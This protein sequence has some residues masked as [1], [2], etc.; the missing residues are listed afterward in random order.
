MSDHKRPA[1]S[2]DET[3]VDRH[4]PPCPRVELP[5][6]ITAELARVR[7]EFEVPRAE[8]MAEM[9]AQTAQLKAKLTAQWTA[10]FDEVRAVRAE[11]ARLR[12]L[13]TAA[14]AEPDPKGQ[15]FS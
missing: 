11:L 13:N 14:A 2:N 7:A 5:V 9:T 6:E 15:L 8:F 10:A 4:A 12:Q 3:D 1:M